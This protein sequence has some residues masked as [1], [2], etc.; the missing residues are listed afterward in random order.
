VPLPTTRKNLFQL[1]TS[2]T[3]AHFSISL[4]HKP[5]HFQIQHFSS[6]VFHFHTWFHTKF[7]HFS[8]VVLSSFHNFK[9]STLHDYFIFLFLKIVFFLTNHIPMF[10]FF[11]ANFKCALFCPIFCHLSCHNEVFQS[12]IFVQSLHILLKIWDSSFILFYKV[13]LNFVFWFLE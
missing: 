6:L 5:F 4:H 10:C 11:V 13:E 7:H 2:T 9:H 8:I 1:P 12:I 3:F